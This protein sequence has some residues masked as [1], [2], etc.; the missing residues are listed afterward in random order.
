MSDH[1]VPNLLLKHLLKMNVIQHLAERH[2][3]VSRLL[4]TSDLQE[5]GLFEENCRIDFI[6]KELQTKKPSQAEVDAHME[7]VMRLLLNLEALYQK[8]YNEPP[9]KEDIIK[10][11]LE[12]NIVFF[13]R[14]SHI[15][16]LP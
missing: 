10:E 4:K 3:L 7:D 8:L 2:Q 5:G 13:P 11:W 15:P 12:Y 9:R 1:A 6:T 14:V 16:M